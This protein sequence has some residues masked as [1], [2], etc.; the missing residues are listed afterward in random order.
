[1]PPVQALGRP[2]AIF[3]G[4]AL[5][6]Q[7]YLFST[8]SSS[9]EYRQ[10][11]LEPTPG[12]SDSSSSRWDDPNRNRHPTVP[13]TLKDFATLD[14]LAETI[15]KAEAYRVFEDKSAKKIHGTAIKGDAVLVQKVR[16]QIKC[17]TT[18]GSW[19]RQD[20]EFTP[21]KHLGDSR[22]AKCDKTFMKALDREGNGHY[23]GEYD[24]SHERFLVRE[25]VKYK[26]VPDET[27]CGPG[28]GTMGLSDERAIYEPFVK[29][30][31]C[32]VM[33]ERSFLVVGDVTQYQIHD[34]IASA[35]KSSFVCYGEL[36][37]LHHSSHGLCNNVALKYA[38]ND[39]LSVPW[40]VDPED[41]EFP[42][43]STVEQAWATPDMLLKYK[44][45]VLNRGLFWR[46]D[47][48]FM[49]ELVFTMKHLWK[50]YPDTLVIYRAT[51]PVSPNCSQFKS[52]GEDEAV[53]N[54]D[55]KSDAEG[56]ILQ[57][58]LQTP[59]RRHETANGEKQEF[60]PTLADIQRQNRIA[61]VI[62]EAAGG[63]F[64]DTEDMFALR[65]DGRMGDGDCARFCAPGP[66]DAYADLLYNTLRILRDK[67]VTA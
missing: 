28:P 26:W 42:S 21:L 29:P 65:P 61:K 27:K 5:I 13:L 48:V 40:A 49:S 64:L 31:F 25:A 44:V 1:M 24:H 20:Q 62:V 55:G 34:V 46:P 58:P 35:F 67:P 16:D 9:H 54:K 59:P 7:I 41:E 36:G 11:D 52:H 19:I 45:L 37:C 15:V 12:P 39:V 56:V 33:D 4:C 66:L 22:F 51:H 50:Y 57:K 32:E 14:T 17:W 23:L 2:L 30:R 63:I 18:H 10:E 53:A 6:F 3:I 43:A 8:N 47:E 38:R 60:R